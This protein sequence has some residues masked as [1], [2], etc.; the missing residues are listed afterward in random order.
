MRLG[1]NKANLI[2]DIHL[3]PRL[4]SLQTGDTLPKRRLKP[5][6]FAQV[7]VAQRVPKDWS[8]VAGPAQGQVG[9]MPA[10]SLGRLF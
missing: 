5:A 8:E 7:M 6:A 9:G 1:M 2:R 3:I 10:P 4:T